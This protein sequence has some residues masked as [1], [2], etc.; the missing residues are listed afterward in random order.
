MDQS[1]RVKRQMPQVIEDDFK[2]KGQGAIPDPELDVLPDGPFKVVA[3]M[4]GFYNQMRIEPGQVFTLADKKH[5][6]KRWMK[7]V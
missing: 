5:F 1:N 3:T 6:G 4:K 2:G 7:L